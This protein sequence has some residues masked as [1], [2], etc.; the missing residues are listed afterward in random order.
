MDREVFMQ[1]F[2]LASGEID[3]E[4]LNN[5]LL[6]SIE[7]NNEPGKPRGF[8]NLIIVTEELSELTKEVTKTLRDKGN[9]E[10]LLQEVADVALCIRYLKEI[11]NISDES[12]NKAIN[13]KINRLD[14]AMSKDGSYR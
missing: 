6:K 9:P 10:D 5:V 14:E 13:V 2:S 1:E 3:E 11:C 4:R 8:H 7:V 12:I